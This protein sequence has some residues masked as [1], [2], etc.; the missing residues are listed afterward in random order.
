MWFV[1]S[2]FFFFFFLNGL[3]AHFFLV[4]NNIPLSGWDFTTVYPFTYWRTFWLLPNFGSYE[5]SCY[6]HVQGFMWTLVSFL[7]FSFCLR[8]AP[9]AYRGSQARGRIGAIATGLHHSHSNARSEPCL[10]LT[11]QLTAKPYPLTHWVRPEIKPVSS[12]VLV[13]FL[14]T[15]PR[16]E[17]L[18]IGFQLLSKYQGAQ[19]WIVW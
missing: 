13:R 4:L 10:Q 6:K 3:T 5:L 19:C 18:D 9:A 1:S 17:L 11:P 2:M 12:W 14:S 7:F 8:A 15:E 16:W